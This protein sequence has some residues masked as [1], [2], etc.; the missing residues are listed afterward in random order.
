MDEPIVLKLPL[1]FK[2]LLPSD[3]SLAS[4]II[5][6]LTSPLTT[7]PN[8]WSS[9]GLALVFFYTVYALLDHCIPSHDINC[10]L[11]ADCIQIYVSSPDLSL[12]PQS[13]ISNCLLDS[14]T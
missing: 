14:S 8:I 9:Q 6:F 7:L 10:Y 3:F 4:L 12:K 5:L 11:H 2:I 1:A 13:Y